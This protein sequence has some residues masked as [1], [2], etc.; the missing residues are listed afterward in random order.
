MST[1]T[2][3]NMQ[4]TS[5]R[6]PCS[7]EWDVDRITP[8]E[9]RAREREGERCDRDELMRHH[10]RF[11][12]RRN[13]VNFKN[14]H[15]EFEYNHYLLCNI[16]HE[17]ITFN[18]HTKCKKKRGEKTTT[19]TIN[20]WRFLFLLCVRLLSRDSCNAIGSKWHNE[21]R[22]RKERQPASGRANRIMCII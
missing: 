8:A 11:R 22:G 1:I 20:I 9:E 3:E 21:R 4:M 14:K 15:C 18:G 5:L 13:A 7:S 16:T 17:T 6:Y 10:H 2:K 19:K 12:L